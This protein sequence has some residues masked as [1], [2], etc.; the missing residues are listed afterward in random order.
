MRCLI[1]AVAGLAFANAPWPS[2]FPDLAVRVSAK[3]QAHPPQCY[4]FLVADVP[5]PPSELCIEK[6][7]GMTPLGTP[8]LQH[9][10]QCDVYVDTNVTVGVACEYRIKKFTVTDLAG[11]ATSTPGI[12]AAAGGVARK[13]GSGGGQHVPR[14]SVGIDAPAAGPGRRR[15]DRVAPRRAAHGGGSGEHQFECLGGPL[16]RTGQRQGAHQGRLQRRPGQREGGLSVRPR[17]GAVFRRPEPRRTSGAPGRLA[18]RR[19]STAIWTAAGRI[20]P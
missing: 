17:A 2:R 14:S 18:G 10:R 11:M 8:P 4:A 9:W 7:S 16:Q 20:R 3:V 6:S 5:Y 12:E 13:G 1:T 19:V 15:L